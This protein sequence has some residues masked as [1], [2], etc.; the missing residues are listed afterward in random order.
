MKTV[1][2]EQRA[3]SRPAERPAAQLPAWAVRALVR[4]DEA[5]VEHLAGVLQDEDAPGTEAARAGR[6]ERLGDTI[7]RLQLRRASIN[8][9]NTLNPTTT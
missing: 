7:R 3:V 8:A 5:L 6:M 9:G 2:S 1:S 4:N